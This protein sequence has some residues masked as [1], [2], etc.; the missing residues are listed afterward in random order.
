MPRTCPRSKTWLR[1]SDDYGVFLAKNFLLSVINAH[2]FEKGLNICAT[3]NHSWRHAIEYPQTVERLGARQALA[4][5]EPQAAICSW[6]PPGNAFEQRVFSARSVELY[7]VIGSRHG[8]AGGDWDSYAAQDRFEWAID[9][10]L[11]SLVIP[12]ELDSAV[13]VFRRKLA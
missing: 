4:K 3:D 11:S 1:V 9:D 13:L 10:N 8:F 2:A 6:P 7:I 5:Y 12:P